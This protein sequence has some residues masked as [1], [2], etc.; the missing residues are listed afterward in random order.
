MPKGF[1]EEEKITITHKLLTECK[2][3]WQMYGYKK[4]SIDMLCQNVGISKGAFYT[5]FDSKESLFYQVIMQ[6]QAQLYELVEQH[7]SIN[8]SKYGVAEALKEIFAEYCDS[9]FM[10]DTK[11]TDFQ[12]FLNKLSQEQLNELNDFGHARAEFM[13]KKPYLKLKID[14]KLTMS[15]LTAILSIVS[16]KDN[17]PS[18]ATEVFSFMIDHLVE[19]I[20]E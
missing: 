12:A 6:T 5:F 17:M 18:Q 4:T 16:Q 9:S 11:S 13:L 7:L 2:M 10:Y 8:P 1:S 14:E 19:N 3:N 20:F 15:V